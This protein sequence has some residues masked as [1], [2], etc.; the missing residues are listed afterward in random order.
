MVDVSVLILAR[1]EEKNIEDCIKSCS[2]ANEVIVID[3]SSTDR[4]KE[5]AENLGARVINRS[6][7]GDWG[8]QQTFAIQQAK[9]DW[10][11]FIDADE[12]CTPELGK[13]I[14]E[15][16]LK[17]EQYAYWI[18]RKNKFHN[19]YATH[20]ALRPDYVCRLMP[21]KGSYVEG[22]VHPAIITPY[23]NKKLKHHMYHFKYDNWEQHLNKINKYTTLAAEKYKIQGKK[24]NFFLDVV[25]RPIWAFFKC[26]I[27]DLGFLDGKIGWV[28][29]VA[30]YYYTTMKY[31]K[32][33]YLYKDDGHL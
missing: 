13:E 10:I 31:A 16:V 27:I 22:E 17:N 11:F 9:Y 15:T 7:N 8:G 18:K 5:L 26:Y 12:R 21:T 23:E 6:M 4:T 25:L 24:V 32:L 14:E 2:F 19:N 20:G 3:D 28:F 33:Y 29:A 1:N 30:H